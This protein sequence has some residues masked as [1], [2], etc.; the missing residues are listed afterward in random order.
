MAMLMNSGGLGANSFGGSDF[1]A[2]MPSRLAQW[3]DFSGSL[4]QRLAGGGDTTEVVIPGNLL[5][6]SFGELSVGHLGAEE[7]MVFSDSMKMGRWNSVM[8]STL[9]FSPFVLLP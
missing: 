9:V 2:C 7:W 4:R 5:T 1:F 3:D 8:D 6:K